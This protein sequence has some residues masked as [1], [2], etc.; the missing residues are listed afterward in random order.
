MSFDAATIQ[1]LQRDL[2]VRMEKMKKELGTS[3]VE[4]SAGGGAVRVVANGNSEIIEVHIKPDVI[5]ASDAEM[6]QDLVL[7]ATNKALEA[8]KQLHETSVS[9][10]T[11]GIKIPGFS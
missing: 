11:G 8:A 7:A 1:R 2:T 10:I 9:S 5:D 3:R 4:G 6:L